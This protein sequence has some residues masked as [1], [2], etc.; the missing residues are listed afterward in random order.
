[1]LLVVSEAVGLVKQALKCGEHLDRIGFWFRKR[2]SG[3]R[4]ELRTDRSLG[5]GLLRVAMRP[6]K[7]DRSRLLLEVKYMLQVLLYRATAV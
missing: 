2:Q 4:V 1:M 5:K 3:A 7:H 6:T